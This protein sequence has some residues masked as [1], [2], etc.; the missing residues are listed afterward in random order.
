M[1]GPWLSQPQRPFEVGG[2]SADLNRS[3]RAARLRRVVIEDYYIEHDT[4]G[5]APRPRFTLEIQLTEDHPFMKEIPPF[6]SVSGVVSE[7]RCPLTE[8]EPGTVMGY[9]CPECSGTTC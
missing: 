4:W 3:L 1:S 6:V 7:H 8:A 5:S 2:I 9:S